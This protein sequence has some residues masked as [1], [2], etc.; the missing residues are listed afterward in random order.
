MTTTIMTVPK[1]SNQEGH[2]ASQEWSG[3]VIIVELQQGKAYNLSIAL[4]TLQT[5]GFDACRRGRLFA[6]HSGIHY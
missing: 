3:E 5:E 2:E 1:K 6:M 4:Q